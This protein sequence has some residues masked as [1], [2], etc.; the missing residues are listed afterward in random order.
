MGFGGEYVHR[1]L[2]EMA[3]AYLFH[4][5]MNHPFVDG[6]KRA[7]A[8]A[9]LVFLADNGYVLTLTDDLAYNLVIGVCEGTATKQQLAATF[10]DHATPLAE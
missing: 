7:A 9:A 3:A 10:R 1:D 8:H 2:F 5:V 6:N 4:I